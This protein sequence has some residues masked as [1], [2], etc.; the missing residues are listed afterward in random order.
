MFPLSAQPPKD[1]FLLNAPIQ[2]ALRIKR[3]SITPIPAAEP[4]EHTYKPPRT[5]SQ[6]KRFLRETQFLLSRIFGSFWRNILRDF[7]LRV[8]FPQM[9]RRVNAGLNRSCPRRG[10]RAGCPVKERP[11]GRR[12]RI[13]NVHKHT[14]ASRKH[15]SCGLTNL[16]V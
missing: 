13:D 11:A 3:Y 12:T 9:V 8:V 5:K 10:L 7:R 2:R 14:S 16:F 15:P 4:E 1:R 6:R